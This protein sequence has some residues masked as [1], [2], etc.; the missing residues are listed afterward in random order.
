[1][2]ESWSVKFLKSLTVAKAAVCS[3]IV[4]L[5]LLLLLLL[6][7]HCLLFLPLRVTVLC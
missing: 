2:A 1:M 3:K 6:F 7:V 4:I 5:L